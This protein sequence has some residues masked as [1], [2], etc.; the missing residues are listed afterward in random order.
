VL[1][2]CAIATARGWPPAAA[3]WNALV[4]GAPGAASLGF[5][6]QDGGEGAAGVLAAVSDRARP[7]ARILWVGVSPEAVKAWAAAGALR[8][9]LASAG[10]GRS[11]DLAVVAVDGT[12]RDAEHRARAGLRADRPVAGAYVDEVPVAFVYARAGAW[13]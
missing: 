9:D 2:P 7:G 6:R 8:A 3:G 5:P 12:D 1:A 4:G 11:A 13:R 10:D